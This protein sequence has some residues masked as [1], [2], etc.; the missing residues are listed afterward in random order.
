MVWGRCVALTTTMANATTASSRVATIAITA[1]LYAVAKGATAFISTPFHVGQLLVGIFVPAF[2]VVVADTTAAAIGAGLGTFLGDVIFLTPT[3]STNPALSLIAGVPANFIAFLL[4]G[5]FV[6]RYK[7]WPAFVAA[8]V[9]FVTLGNLIAATSIVLFGA[10]VF[11]PLTSLVQDYS[12]TSLVLGFTVFWNS[13]SI[14]AILIGVPLLVRA[15]SPLKGRTSI[16]EFYPK[17]SSGGGR[18]SII[19]SV[20]FAAVFLVLA[21]LFFVAVP[22]FLVDNVFIGAESFLIVGLAII[23]L[24]GPVVGIVAGKSEK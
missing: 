12:F 4:F 20:I 11:A 14:P 19:T 10:A 18:T 22:T 15:V 5:W 1:V 9:S 24:V 16:L 2:F 6:K 7:S 8:T 23:V 21:V 17:W 13:T 3:G